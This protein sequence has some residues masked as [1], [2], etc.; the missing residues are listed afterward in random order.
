MKA[1]TALAALPVEPTKRVR[2]IDIIG[3]QPP[4]ALKPF[5][6]DGRVLESAFPGVS[7]EAFTDWVF[8]MRVQPLG[9]VSESNG[10]GLFDMRYKRLADFGFVTNIRYRR[11]AQTNRSVQEA[12]WGSTLTLE[13]FLASASIQYK[14]FCASSRKYLDALRSGELVRPEGVSESGALAIL[15]RGGPGALKKWSDERFEKTEELFKRTNG[16]F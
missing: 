12:D 9:A 6:P 3:F 2:K 15:H 7:H 1:L 13:K 16:W 4:S 11:D 5:R 10:L 14:V 8:A